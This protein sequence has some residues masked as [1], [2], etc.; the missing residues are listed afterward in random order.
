MP[1]SDYRNAGYF[2]ITPGSPEAAAFDAAELTP[3]PVTGDPN[4]N[5][6]DYIPKVRQAPGAGVMRVY[7]LLGEYFDENTPPSGMTQP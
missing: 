4:A 7:R 2:G 6:E 1:L 3:L 5:P